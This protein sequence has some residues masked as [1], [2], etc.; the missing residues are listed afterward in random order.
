MSADNIVEVEGLT[1]DNATL[2]LAAAVEL[3]L[4][5]SVVS[6]TSFGRFLVPQSVAEKA[7]LKSESTDDRE[8]REYDDA[9][10]D[11]DGT[12]AENAPDETEAD[13]EDG[14]VRNEDGSID[15]EKSKK[16]AL[17]DAAKAA[18]LD[19]SGTKA[20]LATRL[21]EKG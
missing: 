10:A 6:T 9:L 14:I 1:S 16:P 18:G 3:G 7:G 15:P 21:N 8:K 17:Q 4:D 2:L 19:D 5:Q 20:D 12:R 13:A 11:A